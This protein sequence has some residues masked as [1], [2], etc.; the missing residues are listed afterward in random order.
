MLLLINNQPPAFRMIFLLELWERFGFYTMQG[1]LTLFFI[2][3]LGFSDSEAYFSFGAF[4]ALVYGMVALGGYLGDHV[5]GPKRTIILGLVTLALGYLSLSITDKAH[6]FLAL[7]LICVGNGLFKAN[8]SNLLSKCYEPND[9]RLH[10]GFTLYYM[11]INLGSTISLFIGPA[12][13]SHYGYSYA[14]FASFIGLLLGIANYWFQRS[15]VSQINTSADL[16]KIKSWEWITIFA[17][18]VLLTF[19]SS[20]LLQHVPIARG[21]LLFVTFIVI[22]LYFIGM[23]GED[24]DSIQRMFVAFVLMI[25]AVVFFTLYQQMPTSLNLFA[26]NNVTPTLMGLSINPQSFQAL[27]PIWIIAMSPILAT[28]YIKLNQRKRSFP[29]PYKF[30]VGML[31]GGLS[32]TLLFFARFFHD[33]TGC[34][35]S[36]WL[37]TSYCFQSIGELFVSALGVAMVAELV[38]QRMTGFV[39]GM[40]FLTSSLAGFTGASVASLTAL[41]HN[42]QPGIESLTIYTGVFLSIGLV[43]LSIGII[44]MVIAAPLSRFIQIRH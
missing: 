42:V 23:R 26:V 4:F 35:S 44:M 37:V 18:I 34:V 38:P 36:L 30:A 32:F 5:L 28:L 1:V 41:P 27:N 25:E 9:P 10:S 14:Y 11:A 8:P 16:K 15:L 2:R 22:T 13:A 17:G 6:V 20:Y 43:T 21:L 19:A 12:L 31:C 39:M 24:K 29:V 3:S 33:D 40:W 7:G